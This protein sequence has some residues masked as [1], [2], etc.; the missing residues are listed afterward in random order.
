[1][2]DCEDE[3]E[4]SEAEMAVGIGAGGP[5]RLVGGWHR[6]RRQFGLPM[7]NAPQDGD[8]NVVQT[9]DDAK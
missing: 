2:Y 4:D 8:G 1:M 5:G 6:Q 9:V 3:I 7:P